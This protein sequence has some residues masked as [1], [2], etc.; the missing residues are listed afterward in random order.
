MGNK[1]SCC[2]YSS[3]QVGRKEL[4]SESATRGLEEHLPEGGVSVNNLQHISEREPEDWDSDPSLHPSAGTIFME[5]SKQAIESMYSCAKMVLRF[6]IRRSEELPRSL[7]LRA[8]NKKRNSLMGRTVLFRRH[9]E[10]KESASNRRRQAFEEEQQ[11]QYDIP[12]R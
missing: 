12:R 2:A 11:L 8:L 7:Q 4:G 5:R 3:P 6:A 1:S 10:E 9:G